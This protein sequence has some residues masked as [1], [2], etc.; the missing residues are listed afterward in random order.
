MSQAHKIK[1]WIKID[2]QIMTTYN[3]VEICS[4]Y[5]HKIKKAN[6]D[7][8]SK[9]IS[10]FESEKSSRWKCNKH[11]FKFSQ[12]SSYFADMF[13]L[14]SAL[15]KREGR[16]LYLVGDQLTHLPPWFQE[17]HTFYGALQF[18]LFLHPSLLGH[19]LR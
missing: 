14:R 17:A 8:C 6:T 18:F 12:T 5:M 7:S 11:V 19:S 15:K 1:S 2:E 16:G 13:S 10:K 9:D 4:P 3:V